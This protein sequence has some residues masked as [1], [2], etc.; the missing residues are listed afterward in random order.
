M[1]SAGQAP[2]PIWRP[3]PP[4]RAP[5]LHHCTCLFLLLYFSLDV[6]LC[7]CLRVSTSVCGGEGQLCVS[8]EAQ[9]RFPNVVYLQ[10]AFFY[11][12]A[13]LGDV[14]AQSSAECQLSPLPP[15]PPRRVCRFTT[16]VGN[17]ARSAESPTRI[18]YSAPAWCLWKKAQG[19]SAFQGKTA[20]CT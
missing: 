16:S 14:K 4:F 15:P 19:R 13:S 9:S 5:R 2:P 20:R 10:T 12:I 7:V 8:G 11:P 3:S 17:Y 1:N 6:C 18:T